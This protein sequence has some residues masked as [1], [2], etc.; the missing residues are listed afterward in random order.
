LDRSSKILP[1]RLWP[2]DYWSCEG[3]AQY[4]EIGETDAG[5]Q[6]L[7]EQ[8]YLL[9][10][11][12]DYFEQFSEEQQAS[13]AEERTAKLY[14]YRQLLLLAQQVDPEVGRKMDTKFSA[15]LDR[16]SAEN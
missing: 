3:A 16:I 5:M 10:Q 9:E 15:Y 4:F 7:Q 1:F 8:R 13:I 6:R 11:W 14:Y 2:V 12:L